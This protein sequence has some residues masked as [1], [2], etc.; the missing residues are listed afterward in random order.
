MTYLMI[1]LSITWIFFLTY[2]II[3]KECIATTYQ[4]A[5]WVVNSIYFIII[6]MVNVPIVILCVIDAIFVISWGIS[7]YLQSKYNTKTLRWIPIVISCLFFV[8]FILRIMVIIGA[9]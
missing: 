2:D 6:E 3:H 5:L 4:D 1:F 7:Y 8:S 9:N